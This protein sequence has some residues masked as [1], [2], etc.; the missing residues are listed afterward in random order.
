MFVLDKR[1]S[2]PLAGAGLL[3]AA[4]RTK[5]A[6]NNNGFDTYGS[7]TQFESAVP[8]AR[9]PVRAARIRPDPRA[10]G[11]PD[12][13]DPEGGHRRQRA[14]GATCRA[15]PTRRTS[16]SAP[17]P[18]TSRS[19]AADSVFLE[20]RGS[21]R[22]RRPETPW[23]CGSRRSSRWVRAPT[24]S[25]CTPTSRTSSTP[26]RSRTSRP[27]T[28]ASSIAGFDQPV[29]FGAPT[30]ITPP[31]QVP[32]RGAL[33]LLA[34]CRLAASPD[35][36]GRV[37]APGAVKASGASSAAVVSSGRSA[38]SSPSSGTMGSWRRAVRQS[39]AGSRDSRQRA[40]W[41]GRPSAP[42]ASRA[43]RSPCS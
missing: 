30:A 38:R 34:T 4:R 20:P 17:A 40:R 13:P 16:G 22:A 28:R 24:G 7:S 35:A 42:D 9:Q 10:E 25:P 19:A 18:S 3:R 36:A 31:R 15:G 2:Q 39:G 26:A 41:R 6:V 23:T 29:Q 32:P 12:V 11:L 33:E 5:A 1:F 37:K 14:S 21:R 27:A 43:A 8:R